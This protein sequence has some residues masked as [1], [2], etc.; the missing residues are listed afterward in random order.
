MRDY[1]SIAVRKEIIKELLGNENQCRK[2]RSFIQSQIYAGKLKDYL[3]KKMEYELGSKSAKKSRKITSINLTKE[4]IRA[5]SKI[6]MREPERAF[7]NLSDD[8]V[9]H[10][11]DLYLWGRVNVRLKRAN[12]L[13]KLQ[14]QVALKVVPKNGIIDFR[15]L[16]PHHY[17]VVPD[18]SDPEVAE[19]YIISNFDRSRVTRGTDNQNQIIADEDDAKL[20]AYRFYWWTKDYN[21]VTNGKGEFLDESFKVYTP[22]AEE[23]KNPIGEIPFVDIARDKDFTFFIDA[24]STVPQFALD[25]AMSLSD[26]ADVIRHQGFA[27]GVFAS[28]DPP[29]NLEA[30]PRQILWLKQDP[31][32]EAGVQPSFQFVS[33]NPDIASSNEFNAGLVSLFLTSRGQNP[34]LINSKGEAQTYTSGL[35]RFLASLEMFEQSQDDLDLFK[36]VEA[37]AYQLLVKWNNAIFQASMEKGGYR[38]EITGRFLSEKSYLDVKF[39]PP[40]LELSKKEQ[41]EVIEKRKNLGLISDIEA[42]MEDR[43]VTKEEAEKIYLELKPQIDSEIDATIDGEDTELSR[44]IEKELDGAR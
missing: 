9:N 20:S 16:Q 7:F 39:K 29:A 27:T 44:E 43:G 2:E 6:Y 40:T 10:A 25:F 3:I 19:A 13:F 22:N 18:E 30:G 42:I 5:E 1:L 33:P 12:Q 14:E 17:D 36:D 21:F 38:P 15:A 35:D 32:D 8:E 34:K 11:N 23:I 28:K 31:N 4:I 26:T 37:D 41:L 24:E